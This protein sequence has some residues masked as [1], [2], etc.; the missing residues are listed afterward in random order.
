[1]IPNSK[2]KHV[3]ERYLRL[4]DRDKQLLQR[5]W[6]LFIHS[7]NTGLKSEMFKIKHNL[8]RELFLKYSYET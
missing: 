2:I 3:Y 6:S 7:K 8:T 1:M 5:D 4:A